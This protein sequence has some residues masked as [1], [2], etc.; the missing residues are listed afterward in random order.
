MF[1][2]FAKKSLSVKEHRKTTKANDFHLPS[3][4]RKGCLPYHA[5]YVYDMSKIYPS[6]SQIKTLVIEPQ[7]T[8]L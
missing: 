1:S 3:F 5:K 2:E 8:W 4:A 7:T 6:A